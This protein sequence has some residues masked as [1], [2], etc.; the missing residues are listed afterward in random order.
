[1]SRVRLSQ[2]EFCLAEFP[3][4]WSA[5]VTVISAEICF[6][7]ETIET[8][9]SQK[10]KLFPF[11]LCD[12]FWKVWNDLRI[13]RESGSVI[14]SELKTIPFG[15][16]R[17]L[18]RKSEMMRK[19]NNRCVIRSTAHCQTDSGGNLEIFI[20]TQLIPID[21]TE[22]QHKSQ[23]WILTFSWNRFTRTFDSTKKRKKHYDELKQT[24]R[25]HWVKLVRNVSHSFRLDKVLSSYA[26]R[27]LWFLHP[28]EENVIQPQLPNFCRNDSNED[29]NDGYST[30]KKSISLQ[31]MLSKTTRVKCAKSGELGKCG[32][33]LNGVR[34][35]KVGS[36]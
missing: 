35:G 27:S 1:V 28:M 15:T 3:F 20:L 33:F 11:E 17:K 8:V 31:L 32:A 13:E 16:L 7:F 18:S 4:Q 34:F 10:G 23:K 36:R 25:I 14:R 12:E 2:L 29:K 9:P 26:D 21:W 24:L 5:S 30:V 6:C 22:F 19:L